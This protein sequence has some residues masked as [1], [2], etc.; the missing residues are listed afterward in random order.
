M[1]TLCII[2]A[3]GGS[4]GLLRK[5]V[6]SLAGQPLIH[7]PI[8]AALCC[9][10]INDVF[11]STDDQEIADK[12]I[13]S[14]A[15]V[16]FLRPAN[17]AKSLTTTEDTLQ[18]ALLEYE[19]HKGFQYDI[20]VF[21]TATAVF[22]SVEWIEEAINTLINN[23]EIESSFLATKTTK[24]FWYENNGKMQRIFDWMK[25]YS[26][27]QIRQSIFIE[28]TGHA[29]ASRSDLWRQG[30]RI[31]DNVHLIENDNTET[32]IDIHTEYDLFLAEKTIEFFKKN[33]PSK[34][35]LFLD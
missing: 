27:R 5:N 34:V 19:K 35:K 24:N 21:L 18:N 29:C 13:D 6:L 10:N 14:G 33:D 16:P 25:I 28:D 7:W 22:R 20:C 17:L 26:S 8:K 12:A 3:R 31:G 9:E 2:P 30:R 15:D 32:F 23:P 4:K 1:K 11:V